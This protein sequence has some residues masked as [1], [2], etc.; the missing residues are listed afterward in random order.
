MNR[1]EFL[2][3]SAAASLSPRSFAAPPP[4]FAPNLDSLAEYKCP[5]WFRDA[6][7]GIWNCWGPESV[8]EFG[9]WYARKMYDPAD[10]TYKQHLETYGHPSKFGYKDMV[11]LW[12]AENWQPDRLMSLYKKAG[13]RYFFAIAQ[14]HDNIDCW[15]S[16][17]HAWNSVKMGP[18]K[19]VLA[20]WGKTARA[21]GLKYG[22]SEHLGASWNWFG[23]SHGAD[24]TG[25]YAHIP[26]DGANPAYASLYHSG[27]EHS[28]WGSWYNNAPQ[29]FQIEW[30]NRIT[31]LIDQTQ[32]DLLYSDGSLPFGQYGMDLLAR[33]YN[34]NIR[35]HGSLEAV[36]F[37]KKNPL[38]GGQF[39]NGF[40]VQDIERG[41]EDHINPLP[42]QTDTCIGD[43]Y[44]KRGFPYKTPTTVIQMLVDIVSKNGNLLLSVPPRGDGTLDSQEESILTALA[45][46]NARNGEAIFASRPWRVYG[47]GHSG[48][49]PGNFNETELTYTAEDIRYTTRAGNLYAFALAWPTSGKL[50]LK[51]L[52][53]VTPT[54]VQLVDGGDSL[55]FTR[56]PDGLSVQLPPSP[57]GAHAYALRIQGIV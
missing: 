51:S 53:G 45:D 21:H 52:V 28:N 12:H 24:P 32:P 31:D 10:P 2:A 35:R 9:D 8:P 55:A 6:K 15:N 50:L 44:Y 42:W 56:Q 43:W 47:E 25:P 19:D 33:Y 17:H 22:V 13:A 4:T 26:Y 3:L 5:E 20:I 23:I 30:S 16:K 7:F 29:S 49:K 37:C 34:A 48:P 27:N 11:P 36:Y 54:A 41:V 39:R 46:W 1:R 18:H 14:H 57:R 40:C 38:D